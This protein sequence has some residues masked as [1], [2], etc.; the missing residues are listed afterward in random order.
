MKKLLS[1][2]LAVTLVLGAMSFMGAF[3]EAEHSKTVNIAMSENATSLDMHILD[4]LGNT[5]IVQMCMEGFV[6]LYEEDGETKYKPLLATDWEISED[7]TEWTLHLREGVKFHNGEPFDSADAACTF[8]RLLD[9]RDTLNVAASNLTFLEGYEVVDDYT[10]KLKLNAPT[11]ENIVLYGLS[12][13][14]IVEDTAWE[15]EGEGYI[16]KQLMYGTGPW[17]FQEWIDG[18]YAYYIKNEDY[19]DENY[20]SYFDDAYLRFI[21]EESTGISSLLAGDIDLYARTTGYA[22]ENL[23]LFEGHEDIELISTDL[24]TVLYM[25]FQCKEGSVFNDINVR[26]AFSMAIDRQSIVDYVMGRGQVTNGFIVSGVLGY[27]ENLPPYEYDPEQA[28]ELLKASGYNGE[29]IVISSNTGTP[30]S[31]EVLQVIVEM[32][33]AVGFNI[34]MEVVESAT[35]LEMRTSGNYDVFMVNVQYEGADPSNVLT[36]RVVNDYHTSN[37]VNEELNRIIV[38]S[39]SELDPEARNELLKQANDIIRNEYAPQC[40]LTQ[41]AETIGQYK[42][43]TGVSYFQSGAFNFVY[44]DWAPEA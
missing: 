27:D 42:G 36:Q 6:G 1:L 16:T 9:N 8:K 12:R 17:I 33:K 40:A 30:Q 19:W 23:A 5:C 38:A 20:D 29:P 44:I 13:A 14:F 37:Y 28:A 32:E 39:N 2:L 43:I 3:A 7:G 10:F 22:T 35:L 18:E 4:N 15:A 24:W 34:S 25:G 31:S 26:K 41:Q 11:P 21:T